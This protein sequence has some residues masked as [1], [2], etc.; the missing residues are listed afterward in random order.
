[1]L[2]KLLFALL[3]AVA[4][5]FAHEEIAIW[6]QLAPGTEDRPNE[7]TLVN[8]RYRNVY[9]PSLSI[10]LPPRELSTGA[11]A[12]VLSG[13]GYSHL[14][15]HKEGSHTANW[16]N[17]LGISAFVLKYRLDR[18]EALQ[19][20]QQAMRV[21]RENA[22]GWGVDLEAVGAVGFSAGAHLLLN[23]VAHADAQTRPD[24]LIVMY[25]LIEDDID[26]A[27]AFPS[28]ASPAFIVAASDDTVTPPDNAISVYQSVLMAEQPAELHLYQSGG[29]GFGLGLDRGPVIDWTD[30]CAVW[31]RSQ[32]LLDQR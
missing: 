15:I 3:F 14:A 27:N 25:P 24:F 20:A 22:A 23:L 19:D 8:E 11:A 10:H 29:H 5:A 1:M 4:P 18:E 30:R 9:Q 12:L 13:G 31:L 26:L 32:G 6:P 7:E 28:N 17:T 16:L 2:P 21:V